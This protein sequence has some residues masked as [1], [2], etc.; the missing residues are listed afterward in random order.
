MAFGPDEPMAQ[1]IAEQSLVGEIRQ[2]IVKGLVGE[3][4]LELLVLGDVAEA[5][6]PPD[7][8]AV[9]PL[10]PGVALEDAAVVEVED[11]VTLRFGPGVELTHLLEKSFRVCELA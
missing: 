10:G 9:D 3:L 8:D 6:H 4:V 11:V 5:P 2:R 1:P 7:S